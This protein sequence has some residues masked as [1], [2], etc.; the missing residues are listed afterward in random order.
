MAVPVYYS[1]PDIITYARR[2]GTY[3]LEDAK[4]NVIHIF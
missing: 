4:I 1:V 3:L 2:A